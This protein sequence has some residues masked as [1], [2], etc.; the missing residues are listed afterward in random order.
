MIAGSVGIEI[1][2]MYAVVVAIDWLIDRFRTA[3]NVSGD[4]MAARI[5]AKVTG[6]TDEDGEGAGVG[7]GQEVLDGIVRENEGVE[8]AGKTS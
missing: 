1:T 8:S 7:G 3:L 4:I 2:G 6:I 5:L